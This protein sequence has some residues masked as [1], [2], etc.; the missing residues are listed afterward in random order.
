MDHASDI[1]Q[2]LSINPSDMILRSKKTFAD[3]DQ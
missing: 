1:V 3:L 2:G